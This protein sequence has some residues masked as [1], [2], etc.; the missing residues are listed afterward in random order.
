LAPQDLS[1]VTR[2]LGTPLSPNQCNDVDVLPNADLSL[3]SAIDETSLIVFVKSCGWLYQACHSVSDLDDNVTCF[4]EPVLVL[5]NVHSI[6][7]SS[8]KKRPIT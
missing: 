6:D 1:Q 5:E 4:L 7:T 3:R 2:V 8:S